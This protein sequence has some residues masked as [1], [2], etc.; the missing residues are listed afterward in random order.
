MQVA[1]DVVRCECPGC[2]QRIELPRADAGHLLICPGC[3]HQFVPANLHRKLQ[4]APPR[5]RAW[6]P[7]PQWLAVA[8]L[9][10]VLGALAASSIAYAGIDG[11]LRI[12]L[13]CILG[14]AGLVIYFLPTAVAFMRDHRNLV[15]LAVLNFFVGWTFLGW[16][17]A[18]V[19][20]LYKEKP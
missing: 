14:L 18:L 11:V 20:A 8:I 16:V 17:G 6:R 10:V 3:A 5:A 4:M 13:F 12:V 9:A 2:A 7:G 1:D 19:W 15:A